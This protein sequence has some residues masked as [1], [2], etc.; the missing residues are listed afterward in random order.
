M[1]TSNPNPRRVLAHT[2]AVLAASGALH[3]PALAQAQAQAQAQP[4]IDKK[5]EALDTVVITAQRVSQLASKTPIAL[6]ALSPEELRS[7]GATTAV[8]LT[9]LVPNVLISAGSSASTDIS[10]R[11]IA[12]TNTTEVGDPAAAFHIDGIYLGR[13][14]SAG[15]TFYDLARIEVLRGPQ[16]TLY[17]RNATAGAINLITNKP[18]KK[19]AAEVNADFGNYNREVVEGMV[20]VPVNDML[21]LRAVLSSTGRDGYLVTASA[22]NGFSKNRDDA[23]NLSGRVHALLSLSPATQVLLTADFNRNK[24]AGNGSVSL[25]T[26]QT[27]TGSEQRTQLGNR[28]EGMR[29]EEGTGLTLEVTQ[30]L[31]FAELTYLGGYRTFDRDSTSST[32]GIT[33]KTVSGFKQQSHELRLASS[34]SKAPLTWVA[35]AY[36]FDERGDIDATFGSIPITPQIPTLF[37]VQRFQQDP[38]TSKSN[39]LFGQAT[40]KLTPVAR[41]TAGMR[42]TKDEKARDGVQSLTVP[43]PLA[44]VSNTAINKAR[45]SYSQT[46]YKLGG[47]FDLSPTTLTYAHVATGYKAGGFFD[48]DNSRGDNTYRPELLTSYE[49]GIKGRFLDNRVRLAAS[50]FRYD[51]K[52]LQ[53]SYITINPLTNATGTITT[54]AARATNQGLEIEGKWL[55]SNSGT[56]NFAVGLLDAKYKSFIFPVVTNRP[57]AIDFAGK[58][59]DKAPSSNITLGY[60]HDWA[61]SDGGN[62]SA[63]L[64]VRRSA[65][66]V[67]SNFAIAAPLQYEQKAFNRSDVNLAYT[68][69]RDKWYVQLYARNLEANNVMTGLTFSTLTGTQV[70]LAEPRVFGVRAGLKF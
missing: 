19:F 11:G 66:Y 50:A 67:L 5:A 10:I 7:A 61:T 44:Q 1:K 29:D 15:A 12:S 36:L 9:N 58:K 34:D 54:N 31:G 16:G 27:K 37:G 45:V 38:V 65:S 46:T 23:R 62:L 55:V 3:A 21:A 41:L 53:V 47:E 59:L 63:Y 52:D 8:N 20:N 39:A 4:D 32:L 57:V 33:S 14:Q 25:A 28:T 42:F 48:G 26:Y 51:Y 69:P 70:L 64:G 68:S 40:Y 17:G 18:G 56:L 6:T 60:T 24:G 43:P 35:G 49:I 2:I 13:P 30:Q 22:A